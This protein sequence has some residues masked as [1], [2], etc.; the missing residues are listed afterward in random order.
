[1][2]KKKVRDVENGVAFGRCT[3]SITRRKRK[4]Q[5]MNYGFGVRRPL[6]IACWGKTKRQQIS[7]GA[8]KKSEKKRRGGRRSEREMGAERARERIK[9]GPRGKRK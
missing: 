6:R 9:F 2:K 3:D 7:S 4:R 1:M 5:K 8:G